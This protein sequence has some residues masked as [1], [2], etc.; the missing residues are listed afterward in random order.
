[1]CTKSACPAMCS[2]QS[3]KVTRKSLTHLCRLRRVQLDERRSL[4]RVLPAIFGLEYEQRGRHSGKW[5]C[6]TSLAV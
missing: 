6:G 2:R 4:K 5:S 3:I 1:M